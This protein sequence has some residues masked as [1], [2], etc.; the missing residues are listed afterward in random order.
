MP[1]LLDYLD[2]FKKQRA[3]VHQKPFEEN[4]KV[5]KAKHNIFVQEL[6]RAGVA[7][8]GEK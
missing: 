7:I 5:F 4:S 8:S 3:F 1:I 6:L 2:H